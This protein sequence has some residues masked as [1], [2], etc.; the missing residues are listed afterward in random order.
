MRSDAAVHGGQEHRLNLSNI[1]AAERSSAFR[2]F[3]ARRNTTVAAM[4]A[5]NTSRAF[6]IAVASN[7]WTNA[8]ERGFDAHVGSFTYVLDDPTVDAGALVVPLVNFLPAN[9]PR[10]RSTM[11]KVREQLSIDGLVYRNFTP[12]LRGEGTFTLCSYW[13]AENL[14][15]AGRL[16]EA[17]TLFERI[18]GHA[19]ELG[20]LS[21]EIDA[22]T[23]QLLGNYPQGY[24]HLALIRTAVRL[25][26]AE[27]A[28]AKRPKTRAKDGIGS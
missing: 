17:R 24:S 26:E 14:I 15:L 27:S 10:V 13:L 28:H 23:G 12:E 3:W 1:Y 25:A 8:F 22:A 4:A 11:R 18:A 19:S 5:A 7:A 20:L 9:D 6:T 21:E 16:D 2:T